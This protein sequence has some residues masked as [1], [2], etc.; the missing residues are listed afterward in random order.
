MNFTWEWVGP[1][2]ADRS[3]EEEEEAEEDSGRDYFSSLCS[4]QSAGQ[5]EGFKMTSSEEQRNVGA[6]RLLRGADPGCSLVPVRV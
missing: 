2:S 3:E 6:V 4:K 1:Q 5:A